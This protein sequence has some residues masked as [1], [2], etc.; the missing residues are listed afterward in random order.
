MVHC[1]L[2]ILAVLSVANAQSSNTFLQQTTYYSTSTCTIGTDIGYVLSKVSPGPCVPVACQTVTDGFVTVSCPPDFP[3]P[4]DITTT[5][6]TAVTNGQCPGLNIQG[7]NYFESQWS[8]KAQTCIPDNTFQ[9]IVSF[10][11]L[12]NYVL[13]QWPG[14]QFEC[15]NDIFS[16]AYQN[17]PI[18][19]TTTGICAGNMGQ[20]QLLFQQSAGTP[21][22]SMYKCYRNQM[23]TGCVGG[24]PP[25]FHENTTIT[26]GDKELSLS[27]LQKGEEPQC[28][29]PHVVVAQG[30]VIRA[31]CSRDVKVLK[32]TAGHLVYTQRGLQKAEDITVKDKVFSDIEEHEGCEVLS[33]EKSRERS[34][35]FGL[36]C[37]KSHVLASGIKTS[38]FEKLHSVPSFWMSVVGKVLG[39]KRASS[40]G[41]YIATL[42]SKLQLL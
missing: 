20:G 38:T 25:C 3:A 37:H 39:I 36:N 21:V 33:N 10:Y 13:G 22:P 30:V 24:Q 9:T 16:L 15:Y 7:L 18:M 35:Y 32:L 27:Q 34:Q 2:V 4:Y 41:D 29:I 6:Y 17:F 8:W 14:R 12:P 42:V 5:T 31:K 28:E 23:S 26:Y 19:D 1:L 11:G 40:V